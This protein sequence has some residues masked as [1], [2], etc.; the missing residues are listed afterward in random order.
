MKYIVIR[1]KSE[2]TKKDEEA[3]ARKCKYWKLILC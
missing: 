3:I 1:K 2:K